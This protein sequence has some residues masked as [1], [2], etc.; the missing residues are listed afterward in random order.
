MGTLQD[1]RMTWMRI[2][3]NHAAPGQTRAGTLALDLSA[4]N[5]DVARSGSTITSQSS[6]RSITGPRAHSFDHRGREEDKRSCYG[7]QAHR[8]ERGT[9]SGLDI[10]SGKWRR[11]IETERF[12]HVMPPENLEIDGVPAEYAD[13][14][15]DP[16]QPSHRQVSGG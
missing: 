3:S 16:A 8:Y 6:G 1:W 9:R 4:A 2:Q 15:A 7:T 12:R 11:W 10:R 5:E 13:D 14:S